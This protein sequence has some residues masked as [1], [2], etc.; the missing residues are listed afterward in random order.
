LFLINTGNPFTVSRKNPVAKMATLHWN[1]FHVQQFAQNNSLT[2][3]HHL[4][5]K[6]LKTNPPSKKGQ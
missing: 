2:V 1:A 3:A 6:H 5:Y 4:L